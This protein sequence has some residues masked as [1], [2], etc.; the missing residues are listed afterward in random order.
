MEGDEFLRPDPGKQPPQLGTGLE[1][2]FNGAYYYTSLFDLPFHGLIEKGAMRTDQYRLHML[3][4][5]SFSEE[6]EA[7][8]EFG[9]QNQA[10]GYMSST[11]YWYADTA[12]PIPLSP[13]QEKLLERPADRFELQ[14]L[15][16]QFFMLERDGLYAD[17]ASRMEY[18]AA[19]YHSQPWVD[20]LKVRALGYREK[21]EGFEAVKAEYLSLASS[22][23]PA[24]AQ[25]AKN[26]LWMEEDASHALLGIHALAKYTLLLDGKQVS[27]GQGTS[28]LEVHRLT[29]TPGDHVWQVDMEPTRQGS[30][31]SLCLRTADGDI[32]SAGEWEEIDV[33]DL[34]G[35][36]R[37]EKFEGKEG[38]PNM[39]LWAFQPSAHVGMQSPAMGIKLWSF[40]DSKPL[41]RRLVLKKT[42]TLGE[43]SALPVRLEQE[44]N[45]EELRAHAID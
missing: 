17:A 18:F 27:Q 35:R 36:A 38:L 26:R 21:T 41:I 8:I 40:W 22:S 24:A 6:F 39:T 5:V 34:A 2:Y 42:W 1:D 32:T 10:K 37:P 45:E 30:F 25:A 28:N 9:D 44:R 16:A 43:R 4:A 33:V 13:E 14:G 23:F 19:R 7:G 31:F 20:V 29:V 15:M 11:A 12:S 3:D